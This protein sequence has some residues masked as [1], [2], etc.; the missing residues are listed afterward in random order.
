MRAEDLMRSRMLADSIRAR[1]A[2]TSFEGRIYGSIILFVKQQILSCNTGRTIYDS[3][4]RLMASYDKALKIT[5]SPL[6]N[7]DGSK[8]D[9]L[10]TFVFRAQ[11]VF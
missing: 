4:T 3:S 5:D 7:S 1:S 9:N 6:S 2:D 11:L 10:D 8:P